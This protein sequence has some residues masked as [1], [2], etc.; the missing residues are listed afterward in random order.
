MVRDYI[1][2]NLRAAF[3]LYKHPLNKKLFGLSPKNL[4]S[5]TR[6]FTVF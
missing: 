4:G 6:V 5:Y 3:S 2:K 1:L